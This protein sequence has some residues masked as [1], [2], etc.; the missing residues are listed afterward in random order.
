MAM[1]NLDG[2]WVNMDT[3]PEYDPAY[4]PNLASFAPDSIPVGSEAW[5]AWYGD[6]GRV[7]PDLSQTI[8]TYD[9]ALGGDFFTQNATPADAGEGGLAG[10]IRGHGYLVPLALMTA[11]AGLGLAGGAA[12]AEGLGGAAA[13]E[14]AAGAGALESG[15][16]GLAGGGFVPAAGS[17][18]NFAID[19]GATYG[20]AGAAGAG[21]GIAGGLGTGAELAG[22]TYGEL[23]VTGLPEGAAGPTYGEMGYT[24]LNQGQ[25]IASADSAAQ[26][27]QILD[28][29]KTANQVRQGASTANSIAK[30]LSGANTAT[31]AVGSTGATSNTGGLNLNSLAS[32]L[33]PSAQTSNYVGQIKA[34]QNPFT[35]TSAGQTL[36]SPGMYDVSGSNLA[37][38]LRKA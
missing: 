38:A 3:N 29:L 30:L 17:G 28:A 35:F 14:G 16:G 11:G 6:A 33:N 9:P 26:N 1:Y 2:T 24:G 4:H 18:A 7:A 8:Q 25:A 5:Y 21:G 37:N 13:A 19:T 22:P 36:A 32:L 12:A 27:A 34:N 23:G 20:L 15:A 10:F 31:K